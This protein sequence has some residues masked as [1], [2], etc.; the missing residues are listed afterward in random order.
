MKRRRRRKKHTGL[1]LESIDNA[2]LLQATD[3]V[4]ERA[5]QSFEGGLRN[6]LHT[7]TECLLKGKTLRNNCTA[8]E[9]SKQSS[10]SS[11]F[12]A[13]P[14]QEKVRKSQW[15]G[16]NTEEVVK[17]PLS[18]KWSTFCIEQPLFLIFSLFLF[19]SRFALMH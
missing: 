15:L 3:P 8:R 7:F 12:H 19:F 5:P 2:L 6:T 1:G 11:L 14:S 9:N 4:E 16:S 13:A 10:K 17:H 18:F